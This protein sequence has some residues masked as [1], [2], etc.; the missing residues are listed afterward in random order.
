[1]KVVTYIH[2]PFEDS[3]SSTYKFMESAERHGY[4][5]VNVGKPGGHVGNGEVL[6]MLYRAY[7]DLD[8]PVIYADGADSYFL[9]P[10]EVPENKILYST[11][12]QIWPP[13]E[14][15]R[16]AWADHPLLSPWAYLNGGG[17]C[18]PA[19]LIAE[20]FERYGLTTHDAGANGQWQQAQAYLQGIAEGFPV[21]LDQ[22]CTQFQTIGFTN[23]GDFQT[24][25]GVLT[26]L[27]TNTKPA[28]IHGNGR[29]PMGWV[30]EIG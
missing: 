17:Y 7:K 27:I 6:R 4:E 11:E 23:D 8:E 20:F 3:T 9:R 1:M 29:T 22:H 15:L 10:L 26:N 16:K 30:Y 25:P 5:V 19:Q 14:S 18:G 13:V 12:K 21:E 2:T 24:A 28:L